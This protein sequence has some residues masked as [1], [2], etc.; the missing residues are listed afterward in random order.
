[1]TG[2]TTEYIGFGYK[3]IYFRRLSGYVG[4]KAGTWGM[5]YEDFQNEYEKLEKWQETTVVLEGKKQ[6]ALI[7]LEI[8]KETPELRNMISHL[9]RSEEITTKN[10][11]HTSDYEM[12]FDKGAK[13]E[14]RIGITILENECYFHQGEREIKLKEEEKEKVL[15]IIEKYQNQKK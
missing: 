14:T 15:G 1:M 12:I 8:V 7:N 2:G 11:Q 5:Q 9:L 10:P 6:E 3:I 4:I 13:Y